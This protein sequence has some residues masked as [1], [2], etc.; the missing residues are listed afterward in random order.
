MQKLPRNTRKTLKANAFRQCF[1]VHSWMMQGRQ[2]H[3]TQLGRRMPLMSVREIR[4]LRGCFCRVRPRTRIMV[5]VWRH[6]HALENIFGLP[7]PNGI[8]MQL[9]P[10]GPRS[11]DGAMTPAAGKPR[12]RVCALLLPL[13]LL[14]LPAPGRTDTKSATLT[15]QLSGAQSDT[16]LTLVPGK[17]EVKFRKE[18]TFGNGKVLRRC[19]TVGPG[20]N[21]FVGYA[22]EFLEPDDLSGPQSECSI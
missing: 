21:D 11:R 2:H 4:E 7:P 14:S 20:K 15:F 5:I 1:F 10:D 12:T 18:P 19:L 6:L 17:Q 9:R 8:T 3:L 13:I 16:A 22:V